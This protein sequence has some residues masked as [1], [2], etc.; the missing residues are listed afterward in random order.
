MQF[1]HITHSASVRCSFIRL[2]NA[3]QQ[4]AFKVVYLQDFVRVVL[5]AC[6]CCTVYT[7]MVQLIPGRCFSI[8]HHRLTR[9]CILS[10]RS[11]QRFLVYLRAHDVLLPE[12]E[13]WVM[14]PI[15]LVRS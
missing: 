15:M 1:A 12:L 5:V 14:C 11:D 6:N 3:M 8:V 9:E 10:T 2:F 4:Y 13:Q 7:Q